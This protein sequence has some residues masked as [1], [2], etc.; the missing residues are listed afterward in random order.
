MKLV[1]CVAV[2][3]VVAATADLLAQPRS[4]E[5]VA[6]VDRGTPDSIEGVLSATAT[7]TPTLIPQVGESWS[8][9]TGIITDQNSGP[10]ILRALSG[11]ELP[12]FS[13]GAET[14]DSASESQ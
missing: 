10:E 1:V 11:N 4:S 3:V 9:G 8:T 12:V 13:C 5:R 2:M 14:L 7:Q 6:L